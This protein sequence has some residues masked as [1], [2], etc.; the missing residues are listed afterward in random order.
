[1]SQ[2]PADKLIQIAGS[3]TGLPL[4]P[5]LTHSKGFD[6]VVPP[7]LHLVKPTPVAAD[8]TVECIRCGRRV[9]WEVASLLG[10]DGF[11]CDGCSSAPTFTA[12][13][14]LARR[15]WPW[16]VGGVM[17][18]CIAVSAAVVV[19][20]QRTAIAREFP[21]EASDAERA[22]LD[23]HSQRWNG[24]RLEAAVAAL[25]AIT[26]LSLGGVCTRSIDQAYN[27]TVPHESPGKLAL[28]A[29]QLKNIGKRGRFRDD[30][31]RFFAMRS[32]DQ[33]ILVVRL[34]A[35]ERPRVVT[36]M[37]RDHEFRAGWRSGAAYLY[38]PDG[39]LLCAGAFEA[40]SSPPSEE[41]LQRHLTSPIIDPLVL[42]LDTR[43]DAAIARALRSVTALD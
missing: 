27:F 2:D 23:A 20:R 30:R 24:P 35:D 36:T 17:V 32:V 26:Q 43:T 9:K 31:E 25:P 12:D 16:I 38:D 10:S 6:P 29:D 19:V 7:D 34:S 41:D 5:L 33:P 42:D 11:A 37:R 1:M 15:K 14:N 22:V 40:T 4:S 21:I 28:V 8:G 18:V 13:T 39:S 3:L